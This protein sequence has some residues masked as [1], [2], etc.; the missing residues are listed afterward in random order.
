MKPAFSYYGGKQRLA[1]RIAAIVNEIDHDCYV[2]PFCGGA[3]VLFEKKPSRREALND[4]NDRVV[5]FFK[6]LRDSPDSLMRLIELTPYARSEHKLGSKPSKDPIEDA[7]RFYA[8]IQQ[9][10][11]N[12]S[13]GSWLATPNI[14]PGS[15][16]GKV[17]NASERLAICVARIR[18]VH[19][20]NVDANRCIKNWD[21]KRTLF[22]CDPPYPKTH[23][24][25][26]K[27]FS[28]DDFSALVE[29]LQSI[30]GRAVLSCYPNAEVPTTWEKIV[31]P[32]S[33]TAGLR[34]SANRPKVDECVWI[35]P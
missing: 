14:A 4:I 28:Q 19:F 35:T 9:S 2:E 22:Y 3:S 6:V 8:D 34:G 33:R 30:K 1:K 16:A 17:I 20:D 12:Q 11:L 24:G 23:Q 5:N 29:Q 31:V 10:V 21:S 15:C 13:C 18:K 26:Y 32:T 25:H 27:G 7:R